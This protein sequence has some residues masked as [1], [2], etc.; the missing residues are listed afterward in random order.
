[1][2]SFSH[3]VA[4]QLDSPCGLMQLQASARG[5]FALRFAH[6]F[7]DLPAA[8]ASDSGWRWLQQGV[9]ELQEYFAGQ[10]QQFSTALDL[11]GTPFQQAVWA[12]VAAIPFGASAAYGAI[13]SQL[14]R[15]GAARAVGAANGDNPLPLFIPC[16]RVLGVNGALTGF[17]GG[18]PNKRW[19]LTHEAQLCGQARLL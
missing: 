5:L 2:K 8:R 9:Q 7:D 16:H 12:R 17:R 19:L 3:R 1:M 18:L 11:Q 6:E 13:A 10:R 14:G 15:P 4:L